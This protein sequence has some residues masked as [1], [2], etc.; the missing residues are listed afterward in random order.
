M[1]VRDA[2]VLQTAARHAA[3]TVTLSVPT[4][5]ERVWRTTEPGTAPPSR[6]LDVVR[7]LADA[8][9]E[10]C[11]AMA[12]ILPGLSDRPEQLEAVVKKARA[13]GAHSIWAN[14]VYLKPGTRE[15]FLQ[16]L[17]HDWPELLPHYE[18][19]Y[20]GRAY[21]PNSETEPVRERV[22][23][24]AARHGVAQRHRSR[25]VT[26]REPVQLSLV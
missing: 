11:V 12:P 8:G 18:R 14:L 7:R 21:L 9:I 20:A 26:T 2:D 4:L 23:Q 3:V 19:L 22:R 13:A 24:L 17:A 10:T 15:H 6:R 1:V 5:D 16:A 25:P